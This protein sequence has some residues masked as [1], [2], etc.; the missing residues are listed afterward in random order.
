MGGSRCGR[1][2]TFWH[3]SGNNA[4]HGMSQVIMLYINKNFSSAMSFNER[5]LFYRILAKHGFYK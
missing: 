2:M 5:S 1:V 4:L 3:V